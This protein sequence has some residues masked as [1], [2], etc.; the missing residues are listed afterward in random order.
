M[1]IAKLLLNGELKFQFNASLCSG[2]LSLKIEQLSFVPKRTPRPHNYV[3]YKQ[4]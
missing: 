2:L 3:N 4:N 1:G